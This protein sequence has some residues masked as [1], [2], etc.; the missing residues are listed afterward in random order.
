MIRRN[1][2]INDIIIENNP[3]RQGF[4]EFVNAQLGIVQKEALHLLEKYKCLRRGGKL[5]TLRDLIP[6]LGRSC[7]FAFNSDVIQ[8][9]L[10]S[11]QHAKSSLQSAVCLAHLWTTNAM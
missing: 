3:H 4:L 11:V 9:L 5:E 2:N 7:L 8:G 6:R 10:Q 1:P